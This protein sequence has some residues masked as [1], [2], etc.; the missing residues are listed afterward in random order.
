MVLES[1]SNLKRREDP[2]GKL[3]FAHGLTPRER[4]ECKKLVQDT[5]KQ[6]MEDTSGE[7]KYRVRGTPGSFRIVKFQIPSANS[8]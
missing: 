4:E 1:L 7:Y 2:Y 3:I 5:K 6:E 8:A